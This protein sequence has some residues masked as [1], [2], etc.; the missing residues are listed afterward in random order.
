MSTTAKYNFVFIIPNALSGIPIPFSQFVK[1][2]DEEGNSTGFYTYD[3]YMTLGGNGEVLT[4][5]G[6]HK[7]L[8]INATSIFDLAQKFPLYIDQVA[9]G[10]VIVEGIETDKWLYE[11]Q[12]NYL[13][14][15]TTDPKAKGYNYDAFREA[16]HLF[17]EN[18]IE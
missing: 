8:S 12:D 7:I 1:P 3:E 2:L 10:T 11:N 13:W 9:P 18:I 14:I 16:S 15:I 6:T 5:N 4:P 17:I